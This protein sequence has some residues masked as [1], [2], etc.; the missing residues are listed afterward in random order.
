MD[1]IQDRKR[2]SKVKSCQGDCEAFRNKLMDGR[3]SLT[4]G[5]LFMQVDAN[6]KPGLFST[7]G[8]V[9]KC[10]DTDRQTQ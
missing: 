7:V 3:K 2:Q 4:I 6:A 8:E 9:F 1:D 10:A 5:S